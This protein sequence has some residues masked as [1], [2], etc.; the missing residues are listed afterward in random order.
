MD[1]RKVFKKKT[2]KEPYFAQVRSSNQGK[3]AHIFV[4]SINKMTLGKS[5]TFSPFDL[6]K[7]GTVAISGFLKVED[8]KNI[9]DETGYILYVPVPF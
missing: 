3:P 7:K 9:P 5:V 1:R 8:S 6:E 4:L 2:I